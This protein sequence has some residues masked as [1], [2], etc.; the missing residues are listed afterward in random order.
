MAGSAASAR[1]RARPPERPFQ[2]RD[3]PLD[4]D[5]PLYGQIY[6]AVRDAILEGRV[7]AGT[8]LPTTRALAEELGISRNT[9]ISA[10]EPLR[11]EGYVH[12]R[13]GAG[14][15]V[16]P[17]V[18]TR[19]LG[20]PADPDR[21]EPGRRGAR[22]AAS[23][24]EAEEVLAS[25]RLSRFGRA[26][27][28]SDPRRLYDAQ[29][30]IPSLRFDFRPCVP[31][32]ERLPLEPWRRSLVRAANHLPSEE[33]DYGD[34]AGALPLRSAIARYVGRARGVRCTAEEIMIVGGVAQA[35][36]LVSRLFV[37]PGDAVVLED[38]HYLGARRSF[39]AAGA[40][41]SAV[42]VDEEGLET[43][44]LPKGVSK[45]AKLKVKNPKSA[46]TNPKLAYVT[47]SHQFPTGAVMSLSRRQALLRWAEE[48]DA[49][50]VEDDYDSEFRYSGQAIEALKSLDQRGRVLYVGT[51]SKTLL[52]SLRV[53]Y[54]VLPKRWGEL[55]RAAK[56]LSDWSSPT[57]EQHALA[58]FIEDGDFE[59]HVRRARTLYAGGRR[60]L[61]QAIEQELAAFAPICSRSQAGLH[62]HVR[63]ENVPASSERAIAL[64]ALA[65]GVGLYPASACYLGERPAPAEWVFGFGRL[66]ESELQAGIAELRSVLEA[67]AAGALH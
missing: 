17:Q 29:A 60:V 50:I 54:L 55:F 56:W 12:S 57:F 66:T 61:V 37:D 41:L 18:E 33:F 35:L 40:S 59:R 46:S 62:L 28:A 8:R 27:L 16:A 10:F 53:A 34:P 48:Q 9:V 67:H 26:L 44:R 23:E 38:P 20:G 6:R 24:D 64:A 63:F 42:P 1:S 30:R 5:G 3:L 32:L 4:G 25:S 51:F 22:E 7:G 47:P 19:R 39:A 43:R 2:I 13:V 58:R 15:F 31:D 14:T 21:A 52:P 49:L 65:R 11:A 45:N 36:D